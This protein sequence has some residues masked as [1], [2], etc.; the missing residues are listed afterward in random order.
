MSAEHARSFQSAFDS[1]CAVVDYEV[2]CSAMDDATTSQQQQ[3]QHTASDATRLFTA[4]TQLEMQTD[5]IAIYLVSGQPAAAAT[6]MSAIIAERRRRKCRS[7]SICACA[8]SD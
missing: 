6:A 2:R 1:F 7:V 4:Y 5:R 3:M 8:A